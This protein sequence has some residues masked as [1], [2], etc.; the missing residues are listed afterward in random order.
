MI[1]YNFLK[2][3]AERNVIVSDG[4]IGS[5]LMTYGLIPGDCPEKFNLENPEIIQNIAQKYL[6]AGAEIIQTNT[7]GASPLKLSDYGLENKV[8]DI[9]SKAV[10]IVKNTVGSS[11]F[12]S[13]SVGPT[14]KMLEP[15]G[16]VS[17]E[18][19]KDNYNTQIKIL[20]DSGV[21]LICVETMIDVIEAEVA[22]EAAR[23]IS[24]NIPIIAT[25]TFD[26]IPK[27]CITIMGNT[28]KEV[29]VNLEEAGVDVI[30]S[31]CGNGTKNMIVIAQEFIK[32]SK[33]PIII[34]S[35]A[36]LPTVVDDNIVYQETPN[37]FKEFSKALF[38]IG[39]SI[40]GGCCGTT[41][42]HVKAIKQ[43]VTE[44]S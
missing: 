28:V 23:N 9:N 20:I 32:N 10:E 6:E 39:V 15:Y 19:V 43:A 26:V 2:H 5:Q 34:Q 4:A 1:N 40:I 12:V 11:A 44:I 27:G 36:G 21:D 41:P 16:T 33:L 25:M 24:S 42:D 29:C 13:G 3:L 8:S 22:V 7:F 31:N 30:G 38:K 17:K 37:D 14:G 35:N 18:E